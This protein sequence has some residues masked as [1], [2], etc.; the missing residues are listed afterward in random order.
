VAKRKKTDEVDVL[1]W[2]ARNMAEDYAEVSDW[3][4]A[5]KQAA[6]GSGPVAVP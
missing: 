4:L 1:H 2:I 5:A 6:K 3:Y